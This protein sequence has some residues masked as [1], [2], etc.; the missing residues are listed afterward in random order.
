MH[1]KLFIPGPVEV[2]QEV[3][4]QMAL[5]LIGHRGKDASQLQENIINNFKKIQA[6]VLWRVLLGAVH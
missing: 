6:V 4:S 1:K 2:R 5:P 3:L